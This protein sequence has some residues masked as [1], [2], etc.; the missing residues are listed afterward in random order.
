MSTRSDDLIKFLT[1]QAFVKSGGD[2][3]FKTGSRIPA[4][5]IKI[6]ENKILK[7]S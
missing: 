2:R 4:A 7:E 3:F 1:A 5:Q 6:T